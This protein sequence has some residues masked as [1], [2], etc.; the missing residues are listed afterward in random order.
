MAAIEYIFPEIAQ[1]LEAILTDA[2]WSVAIATWCL[3]LVTGI[4]AYIGLRAARAAANTFQLE[5]EPVV[6][7]RQLER[8][9][10]PPHN[11]AR[12][13]QSFTV[14]GT[15]LLADGVLSKT[16]HGS[17]PASSCQRVAGA[18]VVGALG[19]AYF[20]ETTSTTRRRRERGWSPG[21]ASNLGPPIQCAANRNEIPMSAL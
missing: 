21:E 2:A 14:A 19:C 4:A 8:E 10:K 11:P 17:E 6:L 12:L 9:E 7:V 3:L 18:A 20:Q 5:A 15:P 1:F 13:L 16:L